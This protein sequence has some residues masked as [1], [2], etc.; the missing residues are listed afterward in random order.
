LATNDAQL[1]GDAQVVLLSIQLSRIGGP[2]LPSAY[3]HHGKFYGALPQAQLLLN[4]T[5][6][7]AATEVVVLLR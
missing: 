6:C 3:K 5:S 1:D 4:K 7:L 2:N